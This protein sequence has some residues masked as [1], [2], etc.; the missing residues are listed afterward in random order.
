MRLFTSLV[1]ST[2][3]I[4]STDKT[5]E[6]AI[7][8][9]GDYKTQT[10]EIMTSRHA[11][12]SSSGAAGTSSSSSCLPLVLDSECQRRERTV[13]SLL[14]IQKAVFARVD[15]DTTTIGLN[16]HHH[17]YGQLRKPP[18]TFASLFHEPTLLCPRTQAIPKLPFIFP[19]KFQRSLPSFSL[20]ADHPVSQS[21]CNGCRH[22]TGMWIYLI[23]S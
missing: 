17:G 3:S 18:F 7:A 23:P 16:P 14:Q 9:A 6:D 12:P 13:Q 21:D 2:V 22:G 1:S 4:L 20:Q 5:E 10:T 11:L 15:L 19:F 8:E